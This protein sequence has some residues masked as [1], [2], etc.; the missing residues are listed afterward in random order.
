MPCG[1]TPL[2]GR[3]KLHCFSIA[4]D[5]LMQ[6]YSS[7][8]IPLAVVLLIAAIAVAVVVAAT[9]WPLSPVLDRVGRPFSRRQ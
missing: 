7:F 5:I 9:L 8:S 4:Y 6:L 3:L 1:L 2:F